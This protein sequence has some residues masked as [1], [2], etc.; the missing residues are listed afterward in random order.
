MGESQAEG[1]CPK[2]GSAMEQG[3]VPDS[4]YGGRHVNHWAH[5]LPEKSFWSGISKPARKI[6]VGTFRCT[7]CGFLESYA[8]DE[9]AAK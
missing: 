8:R 4:I 2:C 7:Q 9:F 6:P 1:T 5:G 3:F